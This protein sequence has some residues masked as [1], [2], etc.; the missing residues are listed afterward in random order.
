MKTT[1]NEPQDLELA[2]TELGCETLAEYASLLGLDA[3][4]LDDPHDRK[5]V[6]QAAIDNARGLAVYLGNSAGN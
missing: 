3:A 4:N 6:E 2:L 5:L 1:L